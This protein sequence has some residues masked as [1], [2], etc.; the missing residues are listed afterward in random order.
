[1]QIVIHGHA[2]EVPRVQWTFARRDAP[3]PAR[4]AG[5][6]EPAPR[7]EPELPL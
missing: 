5:Q 7:K 1:V 6:E 2:R 4:R 3:E